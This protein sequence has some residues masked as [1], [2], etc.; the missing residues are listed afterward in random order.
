MKFVINGAR[1]TSTKTLQLIWDIISIDKT[2]PEEQYLHCF[3]LLLLE[4]SGC[5]PTGLSITADRLS[6]HV[7]S[8]TK[9]NNNNTASAPPSS[10]SSSEGNEE[11][12]VPPITARSLISWTNE[13]A[14]HTHKVFVTFL[15][16]KCF[17]DVELIGYTPFQSPI[18]ESGSSVLNQSDIVPLALYD[19][20]LQGRWKKLY[21]TQADGLSF[22]RIAHHILGYSVSSTRCHQ[23]VSPSSSSDHR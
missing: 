2:V 3:F 13:Y 15:N 23:G 19:I 4:L 9:K 18:L 17:A 21:T 8:I 1:S 5:D 6:S 7:K 22:N 12:A 11:V 20:T 10:V 16:Q 14:P